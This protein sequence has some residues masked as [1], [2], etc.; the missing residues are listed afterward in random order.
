MKKDNKRYTD[1]ELLDILRK[2]NNEVGFPTTRGFRSYL[3]LPNAK[4]YNLRFGSFQDAILRAGIKIPENKKRFFNRV[5]YDKDYLLKVFKEQV[6][7]SI[8]E[9]GLLINDTEI[10]EN[11]T[12]PSASVYYK[13]FSTLDNLY[14]L[15]GIDRNKF[16]NDRLEEDMK[17]KYIKLRNILGR[18][19]TSRDFDKYSKDN[20]YWYCCQAYLNHFGSIHKLQK[21]MGD[22]P[23]ALGREFNKQDMIDGLLKLYKDLD[24]QPTQKDI[25][26]CD[27][28][29]SVSH[30]IREFGSISNALYISGFKPNNKILTTP[31]GNKALSGYEYRFL[32]MLEKYNI[33]FK[34]EEYYKK[35]ID[36]LSCEYRFD[37][38]IYI[39]DKRYF[40]EIFGIEGSDKYDKKTEEKKWLCK[41][42]KLKL[43]DLYSKDLLKTTDEIYKMLIEKINKLNL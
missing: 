29:P 9:R 11:K 36:G 19:P 13:H 34:K 30:Y 1:E 4:T 21:I 38:T 27:Y 8:I 43:I 7:I 37:F 15:I 17:K 10:D 14:S 5:E 39:N 26:Y 40:V 18:T 42:N 2:Y 23:T 32:L 41:N 35:Y 6:D 31:N 12:L 16:N 33:K 24:C 25:Y 20:D 28:I 3:G 22:I